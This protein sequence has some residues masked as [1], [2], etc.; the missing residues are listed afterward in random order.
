[1]EKGSP[2]DSRNEKTFDTGRLTKDSDF[3]GMKVTLLGKEP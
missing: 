3:L 2:Q 1:M